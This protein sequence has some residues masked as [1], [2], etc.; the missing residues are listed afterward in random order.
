MAKLVSKTYGEALFEIAVEE[1]K[2]D[3]FYEE[4]N[5]IMK[6]MADTQE[7]N[8]FLNHPKISK[9]EKIKLIE[10]V[11]ENRIQKEIVGFLR[12]VIQKERIDEWKAIFQYFMDKV[13]LQKGIGVAYVTAAME[14]KDSQKQEITKKLL[15]TTSY[16]EMEMHY[17][18]DETII[19]GLIIRIGDRVVDSTIKSKLTSLKK[20]LYKVQI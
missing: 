2:I 11:F 18:I 14:L 9:E 8:Q 3:V 13:K 12:L 7:L 5:E 19:G 17:N 1:N 10:E 20:D 16:K 15:D 4:V 6:I